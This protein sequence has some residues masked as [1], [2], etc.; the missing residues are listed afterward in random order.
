VRVTTLPVYSRLAADQDVPEEVQARIPAGWRLSTHQVETYRALCSDV[1]IIFNTAMTGD[2]KSLAGQLPMLLHN[3]PV[4]AMYP[5]NAL[6]SDQLRQTEDTLYRW[7]QGD[8]R[9]ARLDAHELDKVEA[10]AEIQALLRF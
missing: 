10:E 6:I 3:R 4:L 7:Q 5:T 1:D 9:L 8:I 2:G